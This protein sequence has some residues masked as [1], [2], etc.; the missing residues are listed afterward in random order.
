MSYLNVVLLLVSGEV[1]YLQFNHNVIVY[2][3]YVS[4]CQH[5]SYHTV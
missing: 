5:T 3:F 4:V 1:M 2:C